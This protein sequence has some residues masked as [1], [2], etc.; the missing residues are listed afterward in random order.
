[1]SVGILGAY[2][3]GPMQEGFWVKK[4][5]FSEYGVIDDFLNGRLTRAEAAM[6]LGVTENQSQTK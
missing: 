3:G 4:K 1:M 6:A 2:L 5:E